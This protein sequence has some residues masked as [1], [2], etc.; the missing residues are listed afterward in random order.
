MTSVYKK[1]LTIACALCLLFFE[2]QGK[3]L[4]DTVRTEVIQEVTVY[5][6]R[7]SDVSSVSTAKSADRK[8]MEAASALQIS[9]VLK[10]FS[11]ATVKDY[12]G[13]GTQ[14]RAG[15]RTRHTRPLRMTASLL[16]T[17]RPRLTRSFWQAG[18]NSGW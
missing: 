18:Q 16:P 14:N 8:L 11:G 6:A 4:S 12:G 1:C 13:R 9:D 3:A 15:A 7:G 10:Y 2:V 17:I 5:G